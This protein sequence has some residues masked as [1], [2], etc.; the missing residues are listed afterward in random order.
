MQLQVLPKLK[1]LLNNPFVVKDLVGVLGDDDPDD[2]L[3]EFSAIIILKSC[4]SAS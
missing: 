2:V 4:N 3:S 1:N